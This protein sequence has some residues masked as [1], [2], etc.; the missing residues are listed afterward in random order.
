[1]GQFGF[2][3]V[4]FTPSE[5]TATQRTE[6]VFNLMHRVFPA[7]KE[8]KCLQLRRTRALFS[9][10]LSVSFTRIKKYDVPMGTFFC[11]ENMIK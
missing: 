6:A 5:L 3:S 4:V 2:G 8:P 7:A 10:D 11:L 1:M 9:R